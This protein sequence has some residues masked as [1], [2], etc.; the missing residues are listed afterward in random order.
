MT[1]KNNPKGH[2]DPNDPATPRSTHPH[3]REPQQRQRR[4][5]LPEIEAVETVPMTS[6]EY[7]RAVTALGALIEHWLRHQ[8]PASDAP[9]A[10]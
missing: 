8:E 1:A 3:G 2:D 10:T 5:R 4:V 9:D 7:E 6:E